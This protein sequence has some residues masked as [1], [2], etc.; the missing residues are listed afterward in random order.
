M[1]YTIDARGGYLR[2]ELLERETAQETRQ[3]ATAILAAMGD[4]GLSKLL[5][6]VRASRA[7]FRVEEYQLSELF[8]QVAA[9]PDLRV[10]VVSDSRGLAAAHEYV[11]LIA[12]QR[13]IRLR[14]FTSEEAALA[15][16]LA[17]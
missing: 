6:V 12:T 5:V 10:A 7:I 4:K 14:A 3:F 13:G 8:N 2:G 1:R 17:P 15:W 9:I 11:Q 16:L